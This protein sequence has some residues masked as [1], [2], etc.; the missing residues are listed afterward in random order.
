MPTETLPFDPNQVPKLLKEGRIKVVKAVPVTPDRPLHGDRRVEKARQLFGEDFLGEE[1][2]HTME[3]KFLAAGV[4]V[5]FVIPQVT[6]PLDESAVQAAKDEERRG[7]A[8]MVVLRPEAM[9]VNG[10]N[11][12][13]TLLEFRNLFKDHP[14]PF[15][16]GKVFYDQTWYDDQDF[17]KQPMAAG[18]ALPTKDVLQDSLNKTWTAQQVLVQQGERRREGIETVWDLVLY[19]AATGKKLLESRWDWGNTR[20]SVDRLVAVGRFGSDGLRVGGWSPTRQLP[21]FGVCLSR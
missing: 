10:Q 14:N 19:Y 8:R 13:V 7:R 5:H 1:A 4:D 9:V 3:A 16:S 11:K 12:P 18:F 17:A 20:A 6:F 2:I 21:D 15:G